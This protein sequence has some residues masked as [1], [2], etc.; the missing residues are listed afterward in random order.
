MIRKIVIALF[1]LLLVGVL[2]FYIYDIT[3]LKTPPAENLIKM[4]AIVV[5]CLAGMAKMITSK[6]GRGR[7][8]FYE[9]L[10]VNELKDVFST[11]ASNR[12]KL[13]YG[14]RFFH[15][16]SYE[17]AIKTL[18]SLKPR[19]QN[20]TD[21]GAVGLFLALSFKEVGLL[22]EAEAT[23]L[24]LIKMNVISSR[25][26]SNLGNIYNEMGREDDAIFYLQLAI[27]HD[28]QNAYAYNN[29][30]GLYFDVKDFENAERYAKEA[31]QLNHKVYQAATLLAIVYSLK[32]DAENAEKYSHI[33]ITGGEQPDKLKKAIAYY[34][35]SQFESSK[36]D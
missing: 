3:V 12:R 26:Y 27:Q 7:L 11:S 21:A 25:I 33:A 2:S 28:P 15:E 23:Y 30:A 9:S 35:F 20:R 31:L 17:K 34:K 29:L 14:I 10:Y 13:L 16:Q 36:D 5:T 19:C 18:S 22:A 4:L 32:N 1:A 6:Q 24:E 8:S